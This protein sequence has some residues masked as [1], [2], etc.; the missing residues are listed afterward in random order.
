[1]EHTMKVEETTASKDLVL[2]S[3]LVSQAHGALLGMNDKIGQAP[4][5]L[6]HAAKLLEAAAR[7]IEEQQS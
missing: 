4:R 1:M 6:R 3:G 7:K 2:A 5:D